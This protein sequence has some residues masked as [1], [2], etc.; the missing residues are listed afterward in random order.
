MA[1]CAESAGKARA[2]K[3]GTIGRPG[4]PGPF[5]RFIHRSNDPHEPP[6]RGAALAWV[7]SKKLIPSNPARDVK[8]PE[9][10]APNEGGLPFRLGELHRVLEAVDMARREPATDDPDAWGAKQISGGDHLHAFGQARGRGGEEASCFDDGASISL[11]RPRRCRC[12]GSIGDREAP[13]WRRDSPRSA[14]PDRLG[15]H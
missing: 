6:I 11:S 15:R 13:G 14:S 5:L 3:L 12:A 7:E 10:V 2:E 9:T 4:P 8:V 1:R